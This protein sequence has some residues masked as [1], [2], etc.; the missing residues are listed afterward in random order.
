M[1]ENA[2]LLYHEEVTAFSPQGVRD[3]DVVTFVN[4]RRSSIASSVEAT[5]ANISNYTGHT[6]AGTLHN[7]PKATGL[8]LFKSNASLQRGSDIVSVLSNQELLA[9]PKTSIAQEITE[10]SKSSFPLIITF[11]LQY[12][13]TV[14]SVFS[15]GRLGL[16][17]LA[18]VS[19]SSMTANI[20]CY[21]IIQGV[22]TCLDTLYAQSYGRKDFSAVGMHMVRCSYLL[23]LLWIPMFILWVVFS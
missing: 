9:E 3:E 4:N 22:A 15:V 16:T 14:A 12:S 6:R 2:P 1:S 10:L 7:P 19:L 23:L 18:A 8:T 13:L 11:L 20:S 21:A 5:G 17:E